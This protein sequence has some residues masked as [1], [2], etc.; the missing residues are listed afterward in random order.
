MKDP[1][2]SQKIV[3]E[4]KAGA[5]NSVIEIGPGTGALTRWLVEK[6]SHLTAIEID[7]QICDLLRSDFPGLEILHEDISGF[8]WQK[9]KDE[10][11]LHVIG[12]IPYYITSPI[13]FSLLDNRNI[14]DEA[15]LMIQKEVAS[16]LVAVPSTKDYGILSVQFQ[17]FTSIELCFTVPRHVFHPVPKVDSAVIRLCFNKQDP[18]CETNVLRR[19]IRT[20]F[21]QRRK[22]LR[23]A[24]KPVMR[25]GAE[26]PADFDLN[27]RAEELHPEEFVTLTNLLSDS[28]ILLL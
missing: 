23:N 16:R 1:N 19:L 14:M 11:P 5:D 26:I 12:N 2:I 24:L 28:G 7:S 4:L 10:A 9:L 3:S 21:N 8:D 6:Y 25:E 15:V 17:L 18:L 20:A 22:K 27:R 13:L